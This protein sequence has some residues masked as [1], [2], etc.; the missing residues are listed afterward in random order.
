MQGTAPR[1][2]TLQDV[3]VAMDGASPPAP[4]AVVATDAGAAGL[5]PSDAL[6]PVWL[7]VGAVTPAGVVLEGNDGAARLLDTDDLR[8]LDAL[9]GARSVRDLRDRTGIVDAG[10]R[11]AALVA[12]GRVRLLPPGEAHVAAVAPAGPAPH[13]QAVPD[14][15]VP[16]PADRR[17]ADPNRVGVH[18]VW[19][20]RVG[21][22]LALGMLTASARQWEGGALSERYDIRRPETPS[23]FLG[24]LADGSGPAVLLCSNYLWSIDHNIA[25][26]RRAKALCPQLVVVHGGPST[27]KYEQDAERFLREH[28]DVADVLV[29]GEG[30]VT[31]CRLLEALAPT[32]PELD[33][34]RLRAVPGLTFR[35]PSR[36]VVVRTDE[37]ER[38]VDLDALPSPYLTGEFDHIDPGAWPFA[39]SVETNRGCPYGCTF[40]DW[41][42]ATLSRIR[43]F[44]SERVLAEFQ[45][46]ADRG[47][48]GLQLC[49]ANFGIL[50]RD[51]DLANALAEIRRRTGSP[52]GLGFTPPKNTTRHI[53]RIFDAVMDAGFL[54]STAISLQSIDEQTLAAVDRANISTDHYLAMAADLRRRG[55]PLMGDLLL[56]LPGQTY[57]SYRRDL[58]FF[59]DHQI[60]AR[61]WVLKVLPNSP[62]NEPGYRERFRVR[63][64]QQGLV[65][66]TAQ[67]SAG[68]RDRALA[69]RRAEIIA[70]RLGVAR[71]LGWFLQWDHGVPVTELLDRVLT[72][73][74]ETPERFPLVSWLFAHFDLH[75]TAPVGW[76]ALYEELGRLV[77]E[78]YGLDPAAGALRTVLDLQ[79]ALMPAPGR[80]FPHTIDL[81]HDY[82]R[83]H[84]EASA[85]LHSTGRASAPLQPLA[86]YPPARF[87]VAGDPL[88]LCETGLHFAGDSRDLVFEGDFA[89]GQNTANELASPLFVRLPVFSGLPVDAEDVALVG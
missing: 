7:W 28:G 73:T 14:F 2:A 35:D 74:A 24:A 33:V 22:A 86:A 79:V 12:A 4:G 83:Y 25:V 20:E 78:D 21:P 26:A 49:D 69:L 64:D 75:P 60:M 9:D 23:E 46:V 57:A 40:C 16:A 61:T 58:Q 56:G 55:H 27:P 29:R 17:P 89:I 59:I 88:G 80:R 85:T 63:I 36:G 10:A 65:T 30:E 38:I 84:R 34:Q 8:L 42:S 68:D 6:A 47:I 37:P 31:I 53:T 62:L 72:V 81:A 1:P 77:A 87:T 70:N 32:L 50:A 45:W 43:K 39:V 18:A 67:L 52:T 19:Q 51:V 41:G 82:V 71:H 5:D 66:S 3:L 15:E 13:P 54:I 48:P 44:S 76:R 11:L